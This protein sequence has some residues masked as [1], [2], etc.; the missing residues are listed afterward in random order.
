MLAG[1]DVQRHYASVGASALSV[2][3]AC[4]LLAGNV[5]PTSVL[6][7]ASGSGRV[8]RWL[9]AA[10]ADADLYVSDVREDS[11]TFCA[12]TLGANAW[13]SDG[14]F[15]AMIPPRTFDLIWCGSLATHLSEDGSRALLRSFHEWLAPRGIAI[16]TF[17]GRRV[18]ENMRDKRLS[19]I[20]ET[21]QLPLLT[22]LAARGYGYVPYDAQPMGCSVNS[23][24]WLVSE[25]MTLGDRVVCISENAWDNHQD[26]FAF[27]RP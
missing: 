9:R 15:A 7:F 20:S 25:A 18:L 16:V 23:L 10:Y 19:Y 3:D 24:Q 13:K 14:D 2:V 12:E 17:H 11:L 26:V 4:L 27:Q 22:A 6:D 1:G 5:A 8:T 21:K